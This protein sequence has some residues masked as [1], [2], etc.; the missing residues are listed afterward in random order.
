M[1]HWHSDRPCLCISTSELQCSRWRGLPEAKL[2]TSLGQTDSEMPQLRQ[3]GQADHEWPSNRCTGLVWSA[4]SP[5]GRD[6]MS[7]PLSG[8]SCTN[9]GLWTAVRKGRS[10][11]T[12]QCRQKH[13]RVNK[14]FWGCKITLLCSLTLSYYLTCKVESAIPQWNSQGKR[15][16]VSLEVSCLG[17]PLAATTCL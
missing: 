14:L 9:G 1:E 11:P 4:S 5:L 13:I 6:A 17:K 3:T 15:P 2:E 10:A 8:S 12:N 7:H 16:F